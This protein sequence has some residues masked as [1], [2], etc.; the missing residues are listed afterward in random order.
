ML[1][2]IK[3]FSVPCSHASMSF[4]TSWVEWLHSPTPTR[5]QCD[6]SEVRVSLELKGDIKEPSTPWKPAAQSMTPSLAHSCV[7]ITPPYTPFHAASFIS[8]WHKLQVLGGGV[9]NGAEERGS[10]CENLCHSSVDELLTRDKHVTGS[11]GSCFLVQYSTDLFYDSGQAFVFFIFTCKRVFSGLGH[12]WLWHS[13]NI[14]AELIGNQY[15]LGYLMFFGYFHW[16]IVN[17][18]DIQTSLWIFYI[19]LMSGVI[20]I[21]MSLKCWYIYNSSCQIHFSLRG[22]ESDKNFRK[23]GASQA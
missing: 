16:K 15:K 7:L 17:V 10:I 8:N 3:S 14:T 9:G 18:S 2:V 5:W 6:Y 12:L 11:Q 22:Q 19:I 21:I 1:I 4:I 23:P 20:D 13:K